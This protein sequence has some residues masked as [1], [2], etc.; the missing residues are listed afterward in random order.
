MVQLHPVREQ[1]RKPLTL[2]PIGS[3]PRVV[4]LD[5]LHLGVAP[6]GTRQILGCGAAAVC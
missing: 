3:R 6:A 4:V 1:R 5:D 2:G